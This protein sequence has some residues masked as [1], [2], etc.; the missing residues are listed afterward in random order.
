MGPSCEKN[1]Y[2]SSEARHLTQCKLEKTGNKVTKRAE[3][4]GLALNTGVGGID[5][6]RPS[7]VPGT[8]GHTRQRHC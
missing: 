2:G 5:F 3:R 1:I 8:G 7:H 6:L 4:Y